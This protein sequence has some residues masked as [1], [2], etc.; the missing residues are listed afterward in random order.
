ME[1]DSNKKKVFY[2]NDISYAI[3]RKLGNIDHL[4]NFNNDEKSVLVLKLK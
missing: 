3:R 2:A 1:C 4:I